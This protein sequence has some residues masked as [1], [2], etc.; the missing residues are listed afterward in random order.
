[1]K[2][3]QKLTPKQRMFCEHYVGGA[4]WNATLA[5][6]LA[7]YSKKTAYSS[8][9]RLLS[10]VEV[11]SRIKKLSENI[12]EKFRNSHAKTLRDIDLLAHFNI[13]DLYDENGNLIPINGLPREVSFAIH[14]I[15]T[16]RRKDGEEWDTIDK[17]KTYDKAKM[18]EMSAK[19]MKLYEDQIVKDIT[20][21]IG[22][23]D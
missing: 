1:M 15:D 21:K 22:F 7:G 9:Q 2:K 14:S 5:A 12:V 16:I 8:G 23:E 19:I 20:I 10:N 17:L 11:A 3:K 13:A 4:M 6:K 18:L